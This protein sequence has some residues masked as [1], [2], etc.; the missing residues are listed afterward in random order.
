M[1]PSG[2]LAQSD[3]LKMDSMWNLPMIKSSL[4]S[5]DVLTLLGRSILDQG[6]GHTTLHKLSCGSMF[7]QCVY[8]RTLDTGSLSQPFFMTPHSWILTLVSSLES[9]VIE[10]P[11]NPSWSGCIE[12]ILRLLLGTFN[13]LQIYFYTYLGPSGMNL[14]HVKYLTDG[15]GTEVRLSSHWKHCSTAS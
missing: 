15:V 13:G 4:Y 8:L 9:T 5:K 2:L 12:F 10:I 6:I 3:G 1:Q 11:M 7:V 14:T